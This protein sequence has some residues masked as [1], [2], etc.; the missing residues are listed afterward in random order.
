MLIKNCIER[1]FVDAKSNFANIN[2]AIG[3]IISRV[4]EADKPDV[5]SAVSAAKRALEG[6]WGSMLPSE[7]VE[8]LNSIADGIEQRFDDFV[9]AEIAD[10]GKPLSQATSIDIQG[11]QQISGSLQIYLKLWQLRVLKPMQALQNRHLQTA[12]KSACVQSEFMYSDLY[13]INL[14]RLLR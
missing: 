14:F 13:S 11:G 7:R 9:A 5:N 3:D 4:V 8:C 2:P 10:T 12:A 6:P 1:V